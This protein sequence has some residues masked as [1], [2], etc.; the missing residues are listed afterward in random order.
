MNAELKQALRSMGYRPLATGVWAKPIAYHLL[1][2][3]MHKG[4]A[5]LENHFVGAGG[6]KLLWD[7]HTLS[8][9]NYT[10]SIKL[11]EYATRTD[12]YQQSDYQFILPEERFADIL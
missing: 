3:K 12:I 8:A 2:V 1:V 9:E 7:R 4:Q 6:Q 11:A 5:E 10:E